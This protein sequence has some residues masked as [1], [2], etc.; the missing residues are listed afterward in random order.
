M[1]LPL[2]IAFRNMKSSEAVSRLF[3]DEGCGF[4]KTEEGK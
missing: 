1:T 3:P 2:Q 4:L